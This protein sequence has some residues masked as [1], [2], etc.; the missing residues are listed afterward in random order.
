MEFEKRCALGF[1]ALSIAFPLLAE[2]MKANGAA[3]PDNPA[4]ILVS[5]IRNVF[6]GLWVLLLALAIVHAVL[7]LRQAHK[8]AISAIE[9]RRRADEQ[10]AKNEIESTK[11]WIESET[12]RLKSLEESLRRKEELR[13]EFWNEKWREL[14]KKKSR[15]SEEATEVALKD[16]E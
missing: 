1:V 4:W 16:F 10:R 9:A 3:M 13:V 14:E 11:R 8:D 2:A 12:Q 5:T 15:T 7:R 6:V